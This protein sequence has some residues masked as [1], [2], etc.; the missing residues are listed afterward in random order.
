MVSHNVR[1]LALLHALCYGFTS[2]PLLYDHH[3]PLSCVRWLRAAACSWPVLLPELQVADTPMF[4]AAAEKP[5]APVQAPA[6]ARSSSNPLPVLAAL[7]ATGAA[8]F[9]GTSLQQQVRAGWL[10]LPRPQS[11][12]PMLHRADLG[13]IEHRA[14]TH[15]CTLCCMRK[16]RAMHEP[17]TRR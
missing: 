12:V 16:E 14:L 15:F 5:A 10:E 1:Q 4:S 9:F 11:R 13:G 8:G 2:L 6:A 7:V 3:A 17:P